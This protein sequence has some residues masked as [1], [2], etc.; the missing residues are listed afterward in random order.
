LF[1]DPF[2]VAAQ[3]KSLATLTH[4]E[5]ICLSAGYTLLLLFEGRA[6]DGLRKARRIARFDRDSLRVLNK[7]KALPRCAFRQNLIT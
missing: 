2:W 7:E 4:E 5:I 6:G 3:R 1:Y